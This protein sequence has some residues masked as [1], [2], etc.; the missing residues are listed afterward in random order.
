MALKT[1]LGTYGGLWA[2]GAQW[3]PNGAPTA[4]DDAAV[5]GVDPVTNTTVFFRAQPFQTI[6]GPG[7]AA[8]LALQGNTA[9]G[10]R[11]FIRQPAGR[12]GNTGFRRQGAGC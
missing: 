12:D 5:T 3:T 4:A 7:S 1:W 9:P 8:T 10:R 11:L 6:T 2:Q